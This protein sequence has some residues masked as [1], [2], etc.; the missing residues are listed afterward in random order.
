MKKFFIII[1]FGERSTHAKEREMRKGSNTNAYHKLYLKAM[2]KEFFIK[3]IQSVSLRLSSISS[4]V[5]DCVCVCVCVKILII[6]NNN[7]KKKKKTSY[8]FLGYA[9]MI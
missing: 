6:L 4:C 2:V 7:K 8:I 1:I 3:S 5:C 9:I